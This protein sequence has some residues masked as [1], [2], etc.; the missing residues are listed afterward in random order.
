[1]PKE[2]TRQESKQ[3]TARD[4]RSRLR[5]ALLLVVVA[6]CFAELASY[7]GL[8][9]LRGAPTGLGGLREERLTLADLG[10]AA[11]DDAAPGEEDGRGAEPDAGDLAVVLRHGGY[12]VLQPYLGFVW[13]PEADLSNNRFLSALE[14]GR[15]GF[16]V[17]PGERTGH[18]AAA[19][20]EV[21]VFGGSVANILFLAGRR[22][23]ERVLAED[24]AIAAR[25]VVVRNYALPGYKQPQQLM[26]LGWLRTLGQTPDLVV[27]VDGF[28]EVALPPT[29]NVPH[30]THP[31]Y[32]RTWAPRLAG[33]PDLE[34]QGAAGELAFLRRRRRDVARSFSHP[35]LA[36]SATGN[37][38]WTSRDQRLASVIA[39][40]E[41]RLAATGGDGPGYA[42]H[43]PAYAATEG[44][45]YADLVGA[46]SRASHAMHGIAAEAGSSYHHF[47]QPNQYLAGSKPLTAEERAR[48]VRPEQ[49][50]GRQVEV[51]YPLLREA[52]ESLRRDGVAFHDLTQ[53]FAA[54]R[55]T[56]YS[57]D[58]CHL[59]GYGNRLLAEAV[60]TAIRDD[61]AA[62]A[63]R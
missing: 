49:A 13:T 60:A 8:W 19:P 61:V 29:E 62:L 42:A 15:L 54:E 4:P 44:R 24:P 20:I 11:A 50:F 35:L 63:R 48:Y 26:T 3:Q 14:I 9:A 31:F 40:A 53:L 59:N 39:D 30:G 58:C 25:G 28:N 33:L 56:V 34:A 23:M 7:A 22:P 18:G 52:G 2:R 51:A 1:M 37:L 36:H 46:W 57:D 21:G 6:L 27:N 12:E 38:L 41:L 43:G 17:D 5:P 45:L 55:R 10:A 47:L 32:P 16:L